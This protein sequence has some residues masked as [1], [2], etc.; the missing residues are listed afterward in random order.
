MNVLQ[1]P[2]FDAHL[3]TG[4]RVALQTAREFGYDVERMDVTASV[5][6]ETCSVHLSPLEE[7]GYITA[8]GDLSLTIDSRSGTVL[9]CQRG[10]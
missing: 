1:E 10:Q 6:G 7:P 8:G 3:L 2:A 5:T 4:I 9:D